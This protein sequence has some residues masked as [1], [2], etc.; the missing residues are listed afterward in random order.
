MKAR[1]SEDFIF[2]QASYFQAKITNASSCIILGTQIIYL[3]LILL[4][5]FD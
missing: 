3:L 4:L 1:I 5:A 2:L